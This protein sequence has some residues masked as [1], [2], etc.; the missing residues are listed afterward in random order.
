MAIY[1]ISFPSPLS[2]HTNGSKEWGVPCPYQP[3]H[4]E[5]W[6]AASRSAS[7]KGKSFA[8]A[9]FEAAPLLICEQAGRQAEKVREFGLAT[10]LKEKCKEI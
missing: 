9:L 3:V 6:E 10:H 4:S 5:R 8:K 7:A 2:K 1:I